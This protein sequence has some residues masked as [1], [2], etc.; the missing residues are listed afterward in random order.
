M[1]KFFSFVLL[2]LFCYSANAQNDIVLKG[3][4]VDI[5]TQLP[6]EMATVYFTTVKDSTVIEYATTDKNGYFSINTKKYDK[7]VFL[8]VNY[9]GY[10]PF[11]E[12][13]KGLL[14]SKDFGKLYLLE[15]VNALDN[16]VIKSEAPPITIKKDTLEFNAASYKVRPDSNVETL[17]KQLPGV[18]VDNNGKITVNGR[19]VTQF[20]VNGKTFFDKDG[21]IALKNLPAEI[22]KKIQVSDFK[23][24]KEELAKQESTSDYSSI[25]LT[26]D[27]KKNKG[28][29]GK[30]LGG[31]GSDDR[32]ESSLILNFFKNKQKIS[33]LASSNNI[34]STGFAMD[35]VFDNM[36]GGRNSKG[37]SQNSGSGKGITQ[38]NLVGVNYS[39][40]WSKDFE[41]M[42]SYNFSNSV[43]KND[44]KSDQTSF[45]PTGN[46]LTSS[47]S[48]T[49]NEN[50]GNK[51]NFEFEYKINPTTR[52]V[53][54]PKV[55]QS[56]SNSNSSS[57]TFS[58][59]E[60]GQSLNESTSESYNES[61]STNFA[62]SL[63]FN[64]VFDKKSRNLSFVFTNNNTRSDSN[65]LNLSETIFYQDNKPND[66]R[67]QNT[68]NSSRS[69]T[70]SAD[71]EYTEPITDSLR[72]RFG[73]DLD[74]A[75]SVNDEKTFNFDPTTQAYTFLNDSLTNY[76]TSKQNAI[77]PKVGITWQKSKFTVNMNSRTSIVDFDNYAL[78]LGSSN[79]LNKRYALPYGNAQIRYKFSRSKNLTFKYDYSNTLPTATQL[80]P[81]LDL[82]NPLNTVTGNPNLNP[83]EKNT[84]GIDFKNFDFR[85]RSGYSLYLKGDYYNNDVV[86]TSI[87][88][89]SGKRKTTYVNISGT[90]IA[91]VGA[92]W[93]Q[94]IKRDA[95]VLR[96]GFGINGS[97]SFDKGFTDA[98]IYNAKSTAIT[99]KVNLTYEYGDL[100]IISPSYSFSYNETKYE[101]YTRDATSNVIHRINLQTTSYWPANLIFGNDFG[102]TYNS[103]IS[104]NFKKDFYLWNTS[105]SYGFFDKK[106]YAKV[107]VYDVLNQNQSATRTI[108]A[109]SIRDEQ[110]TVLKRYIMFSLAYKVGNFGGN[111]KKGKRRQRE[112]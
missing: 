47:D 80:M 108:S 29:F 33:V 30:I 19:E 40:D 7:P 2:S 90:Y 27:E 62:N 39:D 93:N 82:S 106:L 9:M 88:D 91:S 78:Y 34:N 70:Y 52:L 51:A 74:W 50:T 76:T 79:E 58:E 46:I 83:I 20:L 48:K 22:I 49:R 43:N 35:E 94:S 6:L 98:V 36:G 57:S 44:S 56:R 1:T 18:D 25:N 32:Y 3:T 5:N 97:Y 8:K 77:T 24:K 99:P 103:N 87:Y 38:S 102:Y 37:G 100:L 69:D 72:V 84:A 23:T 21:A 86:S 42:S 66:E 85:T 65:G 89:K 41:A 17:L 60:N 11:F 107:K 15:S 110:N 16:V 101:N 68:K 109:T 13:E 53:V 26:I 63:N 81:V 61:T 55:N 12:E 95:H 14:E 64:K 112:E 59:D 45:L 92:Q 75:S 71:I 105:L 10:Q 54:A 104:D 73:T 67:N 4:I 31:Y 111:E 28:F 96:Y